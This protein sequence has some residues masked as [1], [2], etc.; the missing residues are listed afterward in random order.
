MGGRGELG[1]GGEGGGGGGGGG[2]IRQ[3]ERGEE[4]RGESGGGGGGHRLF[5]TQPFGYLGKPRP[6]LL[7]IPDSAPADAVPSPR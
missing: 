1:G 6:L 3:D 5:I 4:G 7:R 2:K